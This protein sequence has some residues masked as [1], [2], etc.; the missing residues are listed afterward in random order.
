MKKQTEEKSY[1]GR[2]LWWITHTTAVYF[3]IVFIALIFWYSNMMF[4]LWI[5]L[6]LICTI[7]NKEVYEYM[8]KYNFWIAGKIGGQ[9]I[10]KAAKTKVYMIYYRVLVFVLGIFLLDLGI[11][12]GK[13]LNLI[14]RISGGLI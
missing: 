14:F 5:I 3:L 7:F 13:I 10:V 8:V 4:L 11:S 6:G 2:F 1:F 12:G 9:K